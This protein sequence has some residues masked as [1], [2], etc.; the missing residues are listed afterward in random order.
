MPCLC[1]LVPC[2]GTPVEQAKRALPDFVFGGRGPHVVHAAPLLAEWE[3]RWREY[4]LLGTYAKNNFFLI[5][6]HKWTFK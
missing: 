2:F 6:F 3:A 5:T 4:G 1:V